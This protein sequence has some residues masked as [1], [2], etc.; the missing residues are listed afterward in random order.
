MHTRHNPFFAGLVVM[1]WGCA[2]PACESEDPPLTPVDAGR[3]DAG[4]ADAGFDFGS[5]TDAGEDLGAESDAGDP[6]LDMGIV[7]DGGPGDAGGSDAGPRVCER[8]PGDYFPDVTTRDTTA[9]PACISDEGVYRQVVAGP[10]GGVTR[11]DQYRQIV[12]L[13]FDPARDPSSDDFLAARTLYVNTADPNAGI[14][15]RLGRR[16]DFHYDG[17][18]PAGTDCTAPGA[19][20]MYPD[21][22]VGPSRLEPLINTAFTL[23]STPGIPNARI[24]AALIEA[25]LLWFQYVSVLSEIRGCTNTLSNCDSAW[26]YY[27]GGADARGGI[28]FGAYVQAADPLAHDRVWDAI[29]AIRCWRDLDT[30]VPAVDLARREAAWEQ[31]DRAMLAGLVTIVRLRTARVAATTGT[32]R[33]AHWTFARTLIGFLDRAARLADPAAADALV[34]QAMRT[35]AAMV[36]VPAVLAALDAVYG[37]P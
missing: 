29:L 20:M 26:A 17:T 9:W 3:A 28:G 10:V 25:G 33:T 1:A 13:L 30:A 4:P 15:I 21:F 36:D 12:G 6:V 19:A 14:A 24:S 18:A 27:T 5:E 32:E 8:T 7:A 37:C 34:A 22:C 2:L 31:V 16:A 11:A 23:G 35:D